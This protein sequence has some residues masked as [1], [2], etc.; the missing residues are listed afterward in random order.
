M[1]SNLPCRALKQLLSTQI[2]THTNMYVG[3]TWWDS[4]PGSAFVWTKRQMLSHSPCNSA[5]G[6]CGCISGLHTIYMEQGC[7]KIP[8]KL[9]VLDERG[10]LDALRQ[11]DQK[12]PNPPTFLSWVQECSLFS[13]SGFLPFLQND[14]PKVSF[15]FW[16]KSHRQPEN[17]EQM[18]AGKRHNQTIQCFH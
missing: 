3:K 7:E 15:S 18:V 6:H 12:T 9:L 11:T 8:T 13:L 4:K 14:L 10:C 1:R 17:K 2:Y 16:S 5:V